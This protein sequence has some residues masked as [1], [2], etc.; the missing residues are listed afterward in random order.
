MKNLIKKKKKNF[1][2]LTEVPNSLYQ[3]FKVSI[4]DY[5]LTTPAQ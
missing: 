2:F 1:F 3:I 5:K 4:Q